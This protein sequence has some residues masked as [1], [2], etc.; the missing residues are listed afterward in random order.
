M[1]GV[2]FVARPDF[3]DSEFQQ[4]F[5]FLNQHA[6]Q[7]HVIG[8]E[9]DLALRGKRG[10]SRARPTHGINE[11]SAGDYDALVIPGGW[12]P[13]GVWTQ[14]GWNSSAP[15]SGPGNRFLPSAAARSS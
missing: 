4:P 14:G 12:S 10:L 11:A 6:C 1:K 3:E 7:V 2:R 8:T 5:D 13:V 15:S 9:K